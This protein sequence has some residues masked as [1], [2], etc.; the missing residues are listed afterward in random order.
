LIE[1]I[2]RVRFISPHPKDLTAEIVAAMS[3]TENV[4]EHLHLPLQSGSDSILSAMHRGYT[5]ERFLRKIEQARSEIDDLSVTTDLIVGFPGESETDFEKT[6]EV[7]AEAQFDAAY[8]YIFSPRPGTDAAEMES[9]FIEHAVAVRRYE[10]LRNVVKRSSLLKHKERVGRVEEVLVEGRSKK[11]TDLIKARTRQNKI[12]HLK[13]QDSLHVGTYARVE[14]TDAPSHYLL[15]E[16]LEVVAAP[17]HRKRIP[18]MAEQS[19]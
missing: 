9:K 8:T 15:G 1:G 10:T 11:G 2:E 7:V 3:K 12:L 13:F 4:C 19:A 16:L 18:V 5:G 17:K 14:V 6:L